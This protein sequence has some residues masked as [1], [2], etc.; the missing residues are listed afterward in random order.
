MIL[1]DISMEGPLENRPSPGLQGRFYFD[2]T[3]NILYRDSGVAWE[4]TTL[5]DA[6]LW[7]PL[8]NGSVANPELIFVNG[9]VVM[10]GGP[11]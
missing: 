4:R 1:Q 5:V 2:T 6:V 3:H 8:T 7:Q 10:V 9:D 11:A